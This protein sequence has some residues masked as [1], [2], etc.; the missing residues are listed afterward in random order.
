M[1]LSQLTFELRK[2]ILK[3]FLKTENM[4]EVQ[5]RRRKEFGDVG[6]HFEHLWLQTPN[7]V[8]LSLFMCE[9]RA[10]KV[11]T[12]FFGTLC[13]CI[14][15]RCLQLVFETLFSQMSTREIARV[16]VWAFK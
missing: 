4:A 8:T 10:S 15:Y 5:R 14:F 11:S 2:C 3:C 1:V 12:Y 6:G 7:T 9:L 13:I 16:C